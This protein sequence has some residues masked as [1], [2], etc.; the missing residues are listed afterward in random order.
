MSLAKKLKK[1]ENLDMEDFMSG[2]SG[3][4]IKQVRAFR[5]KLRTLC[6]DADLIHIAQKRWA[7]QEHTEEHEDSDTIVDRL[8][9]IIVSEMIKNEQEKGWNI[10][11]SPR[12]SKI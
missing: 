8:I 7:G 11:G 12:G 4:N 10:Q 6:A 9:E 5:D 2:M 1:F 3:Y